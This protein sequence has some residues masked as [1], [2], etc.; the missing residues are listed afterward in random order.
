M[1]LVEVD[2]VSVQAPEAV[3]DRPEDPTPR[4]ATA[5]AALAHLKVDLGG[6]DDVVTA[7]PQCLP[8]NLLG[9]A[10]SIHVGG[11]DEVDPLVEGGVDDADTIVVVGVAAILE[12]HGPEAVDTDLDT[13]SAEGAIAHGDGPLLVQPITRSDRSVDRTRHARN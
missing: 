6:E 13:G 1:D 5:V 2:P 3:L 7:P 8:H 9:L 12:H 11:V 4:V 10:L